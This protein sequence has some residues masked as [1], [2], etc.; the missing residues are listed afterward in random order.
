M[1]EHPF[2]DSSSL[3]DDLK[4]AAFDLLT[5]GREHMRAT[6]ATRMAHYTRLAEALAIGEAR[7][8]DE[9]NQENC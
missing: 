8:H 9:I 7:L 6:R 2:D 1:L 4:R 3:S 5:K